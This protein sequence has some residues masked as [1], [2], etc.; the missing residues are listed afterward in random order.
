MRLNGLHFYIFHTPLIIP[1]KSTIHMTDLDICRM[2]L[3]E[4]SLEPISE[5]LHR[6][7]TNSCSDFFLC[8]D[9]DMVN[10]FFISYASTVSTKSTSHENDN[11]QAEHRDH[12]RKQ[13]ACTR[14]Q[15]P[16]LLYNLCIGHITDLESR[17]PVSRTKLD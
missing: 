12:T 5:R 11:I 4:N 2:D 15:N 8:A 10:E 13:I 14:K 17:N 6:S 16:R 7:D 3:L 9:E 1:K